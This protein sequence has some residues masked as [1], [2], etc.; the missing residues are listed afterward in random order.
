M[1][2]VLE[3]E[4]IC[5]FAGR[6]KFEFR[7]GLNEVV[8]PNA[9]GKTSLIKALL[10]MYAPNA[11]PVEEL[12]NLDADEGFIKLEIDGSVYIRRFRREK[13][14]VV[15]VESQPI[16]RDPKLRYIVLDA[17]LGEIVRRIVLETRT[18]LTDYLTDVFEL[19]ELRKKRI[20]LQSKVEQL[21]TKIDYLRKQVVELRVYEGERR[22]LEE[23][24][25]KSLEELEKLKAV[26]IERV[27]EIQI[28][29]NMLNRRLGEIDARL[30][31]LRERLI[32]ATQD[33]LK[34]LQLEIDRLK[35]IV[36]EFYDRYPEPDAY[37]ENLKSLLDQINKQIWD[38][39]RE[40]AD[41]REKQNAMQILIEDA[42]RTGVCPLCKRP[43]ENLE[44]FQSA[45]HEVGS[46]ISNYEA[47]IKS[48]QQE[49]ARLWDEYNKIIKE[50]NEVKEIKSIKLPKYELEYT[51]LTKAL[52]SYE[53]EIKV[54]ENEK[55][56][57]V[58]EI[59][60]LRQRFS[61][62]EQEAAER[63]ARLE[64]EIGRIEQQIKDLEEYMV[65][66]SE[67][68]RE[69]AET[70]QRLKLLQEELNKVEKELYSTLIG[71][72]DE[73]ARIANEVVR[74]L[75]F[76]WIKAVRLASDAEGK[77]FE[78]KIIRVLPSG[79]EVEQ[80]LTTLSTSERSAVALI[81]VLTGY[82]LR[83][84]DEYKG[85]VPII[86]DEALLAFDPQRYEKILEELKKHAKYI[87]VTRLEE[88]GRTPTLRVINR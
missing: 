39:H 58:K 8:A 86:A 72:K 81:A 14:K 60:S 5:G 20:D 83:L 29:I 13:G 38:W 59:E 48:A 52:K 34:T 88:P 15:E 2:I 80:P 7:E 69:L 3:L 33:K 11:V 84:L 37:I 31:D 6:H 82:R 74:E 10:A 62:E 17:Q 46:A 47:K 55:E 32:P 45:I 61:K 68:G 42:M 70:E 63:R 18:D 50:Y 85:L 87:I 35:K 75:G 73:F 53:N 79:R 36:N 56:R 44:V 12:L 22:R 19:D 1:V 28:R 49:W 26:S 71:L 30:K 54:L 16:A 67:A 27:H 64:M 57:I 66:L 21:K 51:N 78:V 25:R 41:H 24:R 9:A 77:K 23:E 65:R 76:G 40:L 4:N 43:V